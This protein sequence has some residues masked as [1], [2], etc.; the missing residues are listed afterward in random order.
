V[1]R[2]F[3]NLGLPQSASRADVKK[4]YRRL[5]MKLHPDKNSNPRAPGL[6]SELQDSYDA[7]MDYLDSNRPQVQK[8]TSEIRKEKTKEERIKEAQKRFINQKLREKQENELYFNKLTK[9]RR[10]KIYQVG[11]FI[12]ALLVLILTVDMILPRFN[13]RDQFSGWSL[14]ESGGLVLDFVHPI[15]LENSG[16]FYIDNA[17]YGDIK[18]YPIAYVERTRI[19]HIPM[20]IIHPVEDKIKAYDLD[21]CFGALLP[22]SIFFFAFPP[23]IFFYRKQS[24]NFS[25]VYFLSLYVIFPLT[26]LFLI[27]ENRWLHLITLGIL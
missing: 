14:K 12:C 25:F 2:H 22:T 10:W 17:I 20:K 21:L 6:F 27:L 3:N 7:L 18:Y 5:A 24:P 11:S 23:I 4:A 19:L 1:E 15:Y 16:K 9:G 8:K 26:I 13:E